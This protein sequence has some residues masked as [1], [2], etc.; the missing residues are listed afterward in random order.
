MYPSMLMPGNGTVRLFKI[1]PG[2]TLP[3]HSHSGTE[4][5]LILRGSYS[6]EIGRFQ[7]G[8]VADVDLMTLTNPLRIRVRNYLFD[9]NR[10]PNC[11]SG[12]SQP[13]FTTNS[14]NLKTP[15]DHSKTPRFQNQDN[16]SL[17]PDLAT[18]LL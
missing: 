7:R 14:R 4:L 17:H 11:L 6:D 8:D 1:T 5:A 3:T 18:F 12:I 15:G 13:R 16:Y 10:R 9:R 2:T